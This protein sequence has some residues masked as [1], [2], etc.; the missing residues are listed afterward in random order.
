M[1]M[2]RTKRVYI[3]WNKYIRQECHFP[4]IG[5]ELKENFCYLRIQWLDQP[6]VANINNGIVAKAPLQM[7]MLPEEAT[8]TTT[9]KAVRTYKMTTQS[10]TIE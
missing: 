2:K 5:M 3:G 8:K 4:V 7:M 9:R 10:L 1:S 6:L